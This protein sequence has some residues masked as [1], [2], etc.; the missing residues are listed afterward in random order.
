MYVY[1]VLILALLCIW[2][3]QKGTKK[4]RNFP[5]GPPIVPIL[6]SIP[7]MK[8]PTLNEKIWSK[9]LADRFGPVI[10]LIMG[11]K[12]F[13]LITDPKVAKQALS[14]DDLIGR[15][16]D[17]LALEVRAHNGKF[18]GLFLA[19]GDNWKHQRRFTLK[20]M[21]DIGIGRSISGD[22]MRF[23][24]DQLVQEFKTMVDRDVLMDGQFNIPVVNVLWFMLANVRYSYDDPEILAFMELLR[25][26]FRG[27]GF[28]KQFFGI[29]K[30]FPN[31]SGLNV[32]R[33]TNQKLRVPIQREID[34][35]KLFHAETNSHM[36]DFIGQ[37]LEEMETD[38]MMNENELMNICQDLFGAG[39]ETVSSTLLFSIA[40]LTM[41]KDVQD[42]CYQEI[43]RLEQDGTQISLQNQNRFVFVNATINEVFRKS[44]L[45]AS[46]IPHRAL[47]D[48]QIMG[49]DIPYDTM[50]LTN[51]LLNNNDPTYHKNPEDFNPKRFINDSGKLIKNEVLTPFG[52]GK[53]VCP[54]ES[55]ARGEIFIFLAK[56]IRAFHFT[57][58]LAHPPPKGDVVWGMARLPKPFHVQIQLRK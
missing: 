18:F 32:R 22:A 15:P 49:Y 7:F 9:D 19:D 29:L 5:P 27:G 52:V 24:A 51:M 1:L 50:I 53:R 25:Q 2:I 23:E 21:K 56:L 6:G 48:T 33:A 41:Y 4:P 45:T 16:R 13:V 44:S 35:H 20:V 31:L 8:G 57:K 55:L 34:A 40:Y 10:G 58:P 3:Y 11:N 43:L 47:R 26:L 36:N 37:Y 14:G 42:E 28:L 46:I 38:P 17:P 39:S 12:P 30:Y 54:G